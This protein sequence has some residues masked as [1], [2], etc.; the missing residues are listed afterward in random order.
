MKINHLILPF[1]SLSLLAPSAARAAGTN[2]PSRLAVELRDGSHIVGTTEENSF[3]FH[4]AVKGETTLD[5]MNIRSVDCTATNAAK[6]TL[7][8]G[9]RL[10]VS[11]VNSSLAVKTSFGKVWLAVEAIRSIRVSSDNGARHALKFNLSNR[12]EIPNSPQLQFGIS[13]FTISFWLKTDSERPLITIISKRTSSSGDGWVV[14]Q[15]HGPL[16]LYSS[17][18]CS[19]TSRPVSTRDGQWHQVALTRLNGILNFYLDGKNVGSGEDTCN[20][21]DNN[22]ILIG[23]DGNGDSW[24]YE[25]ELSEIHLYRRALDANEVME[26][27]NDGLGLNGPVAGGGLVAGYHFDE[28]QGSVAKDFSG[29]QHDGS[30]INGPEWEN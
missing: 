19:T 8:N 25:G 26:E 9:D 12:V 7:A 13:P 29:N 17:G 15:N 18:C 5:L 21:Y 4:S 23:M 10:T 11:F 2:T 14:H 24:H 1:L 20:H 16:M 27:W 28:G 6:L 30:L 22:P 3:K